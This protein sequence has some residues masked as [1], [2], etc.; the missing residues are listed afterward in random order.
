MGYLDPALTEEQMVQIAEER[1]T[2]TRGL[3]VVMNKF[4]KE[5]TTPS[6]FKKAQRAIWKLEHT[7]GELSPLEY[8]YAINHELSRLVNAE[9]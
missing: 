2:T 9:Y 6:L 3:R 8:A 7:N 4:L 5:G 1:A